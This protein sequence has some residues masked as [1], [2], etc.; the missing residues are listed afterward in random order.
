MEL[1]RAARSLGLKARCV[2]SRWDRLRVI[3]LPAL[4]RMREGRW[5]VLARADADTVLV[6][7]PGQPGPRASPEGPSS[8]RGRESC[9]C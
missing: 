4:V 1:L 3:S 9:S 6:Q 5:T 2:R 8:R 7:D